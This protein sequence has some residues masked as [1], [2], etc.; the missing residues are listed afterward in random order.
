MSVAE[1]NPTLNFATQRAALKCKFPEIDHVFDGCMNQ[2]VGLLSDDGVEQ[3]I[4]GAALICTIGCGVEP[5]LIFLEE[6]P[7]IADRIDEAI[8]SVITDVIFKLARGGPNGQ[9]IPAF[10]Q[11]LPEASRRLCSMEQMQHYFDLVFEMAE[12]TSIRKHQHG[13]FYPSPGLTDLL[14]N[15]P[16]LL[17]QLSIEG[18]RNWIDYGIRN[19]SDNANRQKNFF[20][21]KS[22]DARAM[23]QNE[24]H[25]TLFCDYKRNLRFYMR[26]LWQDKQRLIPYS[27]GWDEQRKPTP[28][29]DGQSVCIPDV[30][31]DANN[32]IGLD[33]YRALLAH[34]A[35]HRRWTTPLNVEKYKPLERMAVEILE[36]CRVEYLAMQE[37][38]GLRQIWL[39]LHPVPLEGD[40]DK[41]NESCVRHRL[42]M[43]SYAILNPDHPYKNVAVIDFAER[44]HEIMSSGKSSTV[45]IAKLG[46]SYTVRT[47]RDQDQIP[48]VYVKDTVISHRDDNRHMWIYMDVSDDEELMNQRQD[49]NNPD[50]NDNPGVIDTL[51]PKH[52]PEWDYQTQTYRLDWASVYDGLHPSGNPEQIEKI[53]EK[54][55]A[56]A[57]RLKHLLDALKPQNY[58][59]VRYQEEGSDLDLDVAIRSLLDFK[60][61]AYPD[62]RID[63]SHQHNGR[64]I[65]VTLLIDLSASVNETPEGCSQSVLAISREAVTLLSWAIEKL[66]DTFSI[67]GF[68]SNTRHDVRYFHIKEFTEAFDDDVKARLAAMDGGLSTR[69]GSAIRHAGH[70]LEPEKAEKKLLLILT[71]GEPHDVDVNDEKLLIEDARKA[72]S[73][74]DQ[75][76]I[77]TYCINLDPHADNYV[78]RI[79]RKQYSVIDNVQRLPEKLPKLFMSLTK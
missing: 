62:P 79:F 56:L 7:L 14:K 16:F 29:Y 64:D 24:R 49:V 58:E 78:S 57:K 3:F 4:E 63:M 18:L 37:Y 74:L 27:E 31:D 60:S 53:L 44:F 67:G 70:F 52:Y 25:G 32:V 41:E 77:Y 48:K 15:M 51:P 20:T 69:M 36:D 45:K 65:A 28:Y 2:A 19:Y 1:I 72:V 55:A 5:V 76:N 23:F 8:I 33:R 22:A 40:C 38:P 66:G 11:S 61:G 10:I 68:F 12:R 35:A 71:D 9:S 43:L 59:R 6:V 34:M 50:K 21:M 42:T 13:P 73:E 54:H 30:Y 75:Q 46:L 39:N 26:G 17:S 47:R